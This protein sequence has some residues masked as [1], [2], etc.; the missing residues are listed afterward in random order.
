MAK[1]HIKTG[2]APNAGDG[3]TL[4]AAFEKVN[5]NFDELYAATGAGTFYHLGDDTQFVDIDP[6]SGLVVIQSGFD[7]SMPVYIKGAN[8]SNGGI[9]GDVIIEAGGAGLPN[10]GTT[11]NVEIAGQQVTIDTGGAITSFVMGGGGNP[12]VTFPEFEGGQLAIQS[13]EVASLGAGAPLVLSSTEGEVWI[14]TNSENQWLSWTFGKDGTISVPAFFP[15]TFTA[16][17]DTAHMTQPNPAVSLN[18]TPWQMDVTFNIVGGQIETQIQNIFPILSNPGYVSDYQFSFTD[19]DHGILGYVFS[20]GLQDVTLP[21]GAGW[22]ANIVASPAPSLPPSISSEQT[23]L[24]HGHNT[25]VVSTGENIHEE[26]FRFDGRRLYIPQSGDIVDYLGNTVLGGGGI[27]FG[28]DGSLT[29]AGDLNFTYGGAIFEGGHDLPGRGWR[30][31]LNIVGSQT[32]STDPVRIYPYGTDGKGLGMG[33]VI[34][35]H[36]R[37]VIQSNNQGYGN[38]GTSW[39]FDNQGA[40]T[41]PHN[42]NTLLNYG[43]LYFGDYGT[44]TNMFVDSQTY[45][46]QIYTNTGGQRG[47]NWVFKTN[48][49]TVLPGNINSANSID[50]KIGTGV[51]NSS[52]NSVSDGGTQLHIAKVVDAAIGEIVKPGWQISTSWGG[53]IAKVTVIAEGTG[54]FG[55]EWIFVIDRDISSGFIGGAQVTFGIPESTWTFGEHNILTLPAG[56]DIVDS[57]GETVLGFAASYY[58]GYTVLLSYEDGHITVTGDVTS[59]FSTDQIIKFSTLTEDEYTVGT[60]TYDSGNDWTA[61]TLVE[62]L[63][64]PVDS[65]PILFEKY[66]ISEIYPGEGIQ[67]TLMNNVLTLSALPQR[68]L[69][70]GHQVILD[71]NGIL[72][73]PVTSVP[74]HST[75]AVGDVQGMIAFSGDYIYYCKQDYT[76]GMGDIWVRSAWTSTSW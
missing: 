13:S 46:L 62:G 27:Q 26:Q 75:G 2:T 65:E 25:V 61:I 70:N 12:Y 16:V 9:G 60:V 14:K 33:T 34:V 63:G 52:A 35:D 15:R 30:T 57:T 18:N 19:A 20:I 36:D 28:E 55:P 17:L 39:T 71:E 29:L 37:V 4:R 74:T 56:G 54:S 69:N 23:L 68:L 21:G 31:G 67:S 41:M 32:T 40:L 53:H 38:P 48:G 49:D 51:Y 43:H 72:T 5:S 47:G 44:G 24:L 11:G 58:S 42:G 45:D 7:T 73:I 6:T 22:T 76:D 8:C 66:N 50:V 3:D 1:Q 59:V 10:S 64:G